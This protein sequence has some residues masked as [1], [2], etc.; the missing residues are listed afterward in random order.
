M[1]RQNMRCSTFSQ[2]LHVEAGSGAELVLLRSWP[3]PPGFFRSGACA[4]R[5]SVAASAGRVDV[6]GW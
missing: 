3:V 5:R 6:R 1:K 2:E 4:L